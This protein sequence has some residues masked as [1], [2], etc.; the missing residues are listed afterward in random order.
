ML[1]R[2]ACRRRAIEMSKESPADGVGMAI[3]SR[4]NRS[5]S[6]RRS[7][8]ISRRRRRT[9]TRIPLSIVTC[10]AGMT[11]ALGSLVLMP[12]VASAAPTTWSANPT[13][14]PSPTTNVLNGVSCPGA[15]LCIAVGYYQTG[16]TDQTLTEILQSN[17]WTAVDSP[18]KGAYDNALN[19]VSCP[20]STFC[21]AVGYVIDKAG[22]ANTLVETFDGSS[23][24]VVKSAGSGKFGN[25]LNGISCVSSISCEAVGSSTDAQ[26]GTAPL[27]EQ[28]NGQVWSVVS[29]ADPGGAQAPNALNGLS[30]TSATSC[31]AA[32]TYSAEPG[33]EQ[34]TLIEDWDGAS[35]SQAPSPDPGSSANVLNGVSCTTSPDFCVA[36]GYFSNG[37]V[38]DTLVLTSSGGGA[39]TIS[40]SNDP[41]TTANDLEA[42]VCGSG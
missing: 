19:S 5:S 32:G 30:C 27:A 41:G 40:S 36:T 38:E 1:C 4:H 6:G 16:S 9:L 25:E 3:S 8:R 7:S 24:D 2:Q 14:A 39:W 10:V 28:W 42:R 11:G 20:T 15:N 37:S 31:V 23:W 17:S 34:L 21:D 29:S 13:P 35:W 12:G 33:G 22:V 18:D 26:G